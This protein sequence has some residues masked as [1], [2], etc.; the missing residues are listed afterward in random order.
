MINWFSDNLMQAN[1]SKFKCILFG[2][3]E[4]ENL[5]FSENITLDIV[6]SVKL[7]GV[8]INKKFTYDVPRPGMIH[9]QSN[10]YIKTALTLCCKP[11]VIHV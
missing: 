2:S 11:V 3:K 10:L 6:G 8:D 5:Q 7:L 9:V 1:P 4:K